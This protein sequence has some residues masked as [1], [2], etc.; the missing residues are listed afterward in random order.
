[1]C[2][3]NWPQNKHLASLDSTS[4]SSLSQDW[5][6]SPCVGI[7]SRKNHRGIAHPRPGGSAWPPLIT[8]QQFWNPF[9]AEVFVMGA[10]SQ[11]DPATT[12][13][14]VSESDSAGPKP[15]IATGVASSDF[16]STYADYA[17]V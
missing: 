5:P 17:D 7:G 13:A 14:S 10:V 2:R 3:T 9:T 11:S 1:M 4:E 16:I 6:L 12:A 8:A 15:A